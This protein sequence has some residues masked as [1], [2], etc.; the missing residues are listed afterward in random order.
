[1]AKSVHCECSVGAWHSSENAVGSSDHG[2]TVHR[3][4]YVRSKE[5]WTRTKSGATQ[6]LRYRLGRE[7]ERKDLRTNM[8]VIR[9]VTRNFVA[10]GA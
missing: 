10:V 4:V 3:D 1:M 6:R 5:V 8:V 9:N 2:L 7:W